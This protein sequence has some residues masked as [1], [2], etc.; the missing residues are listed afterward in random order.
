MLSVKLYYNPRSGEKNGRFK[1]LASQISKEGFR[2]VKAVHHK[3]GLA[4]ISPELDLVA[5]AGG[6]GTV[7]RAC[8][9]LLEQPL[10]RFRPLGILPLGTANNIAR[11]LNITGTLTEIIQSW[12]KRQY[13]QL[14]VGRCFSGDEKERFFVEGCGWGL[15]PQLI[16]AMVEIPRQLRNTPDKELKSALQI[17]RQLTLAGKAYKGT[18][19]VDGKNHRGKF[20]MAEMMNIPQIG[21][22]LAL[23]PDA[24]CGD[25]YL[26]V[27]LLEEHQREAFC[28]Y[29][30]SLIKGKLLMSPFPTIKARSIQIFWDDLP[31]MHLDDALLAAKYG[32][33]IS[34]D[35]LP[36]SFQFL[37]G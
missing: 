29:L 11:S 4:P 21:P 32:N 31:K 27:F 14:N 19:S 35:L 8:M 6:D 36:T 9:E 15:F 18:V 7:R 33:N 30:D 23:A 20:L 2:M 25:G 16:Q 12:H 24:D 22:R 37:I 34:I 1:A 17:L 10:S 5:V 13:R 26:D 3:K 28:Q